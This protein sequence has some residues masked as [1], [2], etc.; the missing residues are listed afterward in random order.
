[1]N[2][3]N[4]VNMNKKNSFKLLNGTEADA[5][6][7]LAQWYFDEW[8]MPIERAT[9]RLT[10]LDPT[11]IVFH[12]AMLLDGELIGG[13]GLHVNVGLFHEHERF[14]AQGPWLAI[15]YTDK[16]HRGKGCGKLLLDAVEEE[17]KKRGFAKLY[18]YTS[19]AENLYA[20]NGWKTTE[21]LVY[22][23]QENVVMEK[24]I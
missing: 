4:V 20:R 17:A 16:K 19:T 3:K 11:D 12:F 15:L 24:E 5:I 8:G 7:Q 13:G 22:K 1:M 21:K 14:K 23:G 9:K 2:K 6:S 18:L 10:E